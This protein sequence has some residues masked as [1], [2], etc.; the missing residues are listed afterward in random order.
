[1]DEVFQNVTDVDNGRCSVDPLVVVWPLSAQDVSAAL[2][3]ARACALQLSVISGGHS[4][5]C[6]SLTDQGMTI[7]LSE[8]NDIRPNLITGEMTVQAG[9]IFKDVYTS[10]FN[11]SEGADNTRWT[12]V[13]GG[14]PYVGVGGFF[15]G[16]G[17][18]FLSRSYGLATDMLLGVTTVL[19]DGSVLV[20]NASSACQSAPRC[21]ELWWASRGG[22][23]G[24]FG[25]VTEYHF[26]MV[27]SPKEILVGQLCWAP[28]TDLLGAVWGWL[29]DVYPTLPDWIQ[30]DSGWLPLGED[31]DRLFCHTVICNHAS[32]ADCMDII[33]PVIDIGGV[34]LNDLAMQPF[35]SWQI[36]HDSITSAQHGQLYLT[37]VMMDEGVCGVECIL[38]IQD[39]VVS[40][41]SSRNIVITHMGGGA[42]SRLGPADTSF[43]HRQSQFVLQV[44]AIW[45]NDDSTASAISNIAWV[46]QLKAWLTPMST[47]SYVNY[48]DPYLADFAEKYYGNNLARLQQAK[49]L[50]DPEYVFLFN[51]SI[52]Y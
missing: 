49:R 18:S 3:T 34:V 39:A 13:G 20:A 38:R 8:L 26:Q 46:D 5:A 10:V 44:K 35:L 25:I 28:D 45:S 17:W 12:P 19:A 27:L 40:A 50:L 16:G 14:C 51:Q 42:L 48:M 32:A 31:G 29:I 22:G 30:I 2:A 33:Q 1:A 24:N 52:V 6:F 36:Q 47:G 9:A 4:A 37:N 23:G 21:R 11:I 41:P 43:P 15:L 7:S